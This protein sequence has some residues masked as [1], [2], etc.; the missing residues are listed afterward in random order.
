MHSLYADDLTPSETIQMDTSK[1]LGFVTKEGTPT[2]HTAILARALGVP[3][4]VATGED[5]DY[6]YDGKTA[7]IDGFSGTVYLEPTPGVLSVMKEKQDQ[8]IRLKQLLQELKGVPSE[9]KD[10]RRI[11]VAANVSSAADL[12]AVLKNDAEGIGLFRSEFIYMGRDT[13]PSEEEQFNIYKLAVETMTGKRVIIRTLDIGGDKDASAFHLPKE[14][15]PALGMRAI[16]IS[17]KGRKYSRHSFA[18]FSVPAHSARLQ[19]CSRSSLR[20]GKYG[21]QRKSWMRSN[22]IWIRKALPM[23]IRSRSAS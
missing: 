7:V 18:L 1:I 2:S 6:A 21:K 8:S 3:A 22:W 20:Y 4:I 19:S 5:V 17:L 10:G 12:A 14:E 15:N 16:R 11:E 23:T 9:T 13:L